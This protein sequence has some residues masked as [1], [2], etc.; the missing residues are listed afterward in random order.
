MLRQV[1]SAVLHVMMMV[2]YMPLQEHRNFKGYFKGH[3]SKRYYKP[4]WF[5]SGAVGI[6]RRFLGA[7][8]RGDKIIWSFG[9]NACHMDAKMQLGED[10]VRK[11]G[12]GM[13]ENEVKAWV[14]EM[15]RG[16]D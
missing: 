5:V 8:G 13:A 2:L 15:C 12:G 14:D 16:A 3:Y 11:L 4:T 1:A 7:N 9:R 10:C 6:C